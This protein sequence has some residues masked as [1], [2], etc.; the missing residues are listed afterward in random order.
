MTMPSKIKT[1]ADL[2]LVLDHLIYEHPDENSESM[3]KYT[4]NLCGAYGDYWD[5]IFEHILMDHQTTKIDTLEHPGDDRP[6][7]RN[8]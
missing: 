7:P 4:C 1:V 5:E 3:H 6:C 2:S 8:I